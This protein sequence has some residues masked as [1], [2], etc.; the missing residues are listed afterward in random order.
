MNGRRRGSGSASQNAS[1]P[2]GSDFLMRRTIP[3]YGLPLMWKGLFPGGHGSGGA[4]P[5]PSGELSARSSRVGASE[6]ARGASVVEV[7]AIEPGAIDAGAL[8]I[9]RARRIDG[10][11]I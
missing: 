5:R 6:G 9:V 1:R 7:G 4:S 2:P 11:E 10:R 3:R 8:E